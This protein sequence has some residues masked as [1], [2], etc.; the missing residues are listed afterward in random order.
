MIQEKQIIDKIEVV[1]GVF[2]QVRQ[3]NIIEKDGV[4]IART[5]HRWSFT[6]LD[7]ISEQPQQ[8][9]DI[10]SV[11]WTKEVINAYKQLSSQPLI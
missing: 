4:E 1:N 6:P 7:D 11:V 3:A 8:V 5:Y 2:I 9:K 10:A